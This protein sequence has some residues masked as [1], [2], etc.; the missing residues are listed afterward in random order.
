MIDKTLTVV[1]ITFILFSAA[2]ITRNGDL[3]WMMLPF[4]AYLGVGILQTPNLERLSFSAKRTLTQTRTSGIL[5]IIVNLAIQNQAAETVHLFV[6]EEAQE[7][8]KITDGELKQWSTVRPGE[9]TEMSYSF[10]AA[11]GDFSWESIQTMVSDPLGLIKT[12]LLLPANATIQMRPQIKR[13][14]SIPWRP[15]NTVHSPGS[16]PARLS[17]SGTDFFGVREYHPGDSLR[18]LDWRLTARHPRKFFTKEF[19]Q[20]EI[21]EI[22]LIL[23]ARQNT[24]LRIGE[25]SLFE[26]GVG[27]TASLAEMFLH[28]QNRVSLLV[29][30]KG[31]LSVFP[32][33]G[34]TQLHRIISCLSKAKAAGESHKLGNFDLLPIRMFPIHSS[35]IVISSLA[36]TDRS[37]FQHLRAYGYQ[38]LLVSPNPIDFAY[39]TL[40]QDTVNQ[41]A[42]RAAC[43]ERRLWLNDIAKLHIP[44]I[45]WP[46]NQPLFPLV[47]NAITRSRGKRER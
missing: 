4:L 9:S 3:A 16:I 44:V 14:K 33:Y 7:G 6:H 30:G 11:R 42:I 29:F 25:E 47:R 19:E 18:T 28:Q 39:S 37:L 12:D 35:I 40:A 21:A 27:A 8:M 24:D 15:H 22:G 31:M 10:E 34:K 2:L 45:D 13:F 43:I 46:V 5:S 32:G 41:L 20:E 1:L 36:S 17:G 23:D 26:Y 38:V